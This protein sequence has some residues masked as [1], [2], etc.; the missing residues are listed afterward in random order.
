VL[1]ALPL[2][3]LIAVQ[4]M[5]PGYMQPLFQGFGLFV[6]AGTALSVIAGV[7]VINRMVKID[8]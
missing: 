5:S 7:A 4:V 8:V 6:L 1:G 2:F 3:L